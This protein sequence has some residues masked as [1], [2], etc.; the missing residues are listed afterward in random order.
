MWS[1]RGDPVLHIDLGKWADLMLIAPL[2]ANCLAKMAQVI[3]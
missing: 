2:D 3:L 1:H